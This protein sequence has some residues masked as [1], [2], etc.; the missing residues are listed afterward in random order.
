MNAPLDVPAEGRDT[1]AEP[2]AQ[3][4][5]DA[6]AIRRGHLRVRT[7][8]SLRWVTL[9][10]E[11]ALLAAMAFGLGYPAPYFTAAVVV[12]AGAFVCVLPYELTPEQT[13]AKIVAAMQ[14]GASA[15]SC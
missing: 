4:V 9:A 8:V 11:L 14:Q 13:A 2:A 15:D 10:G 7:L 12:A 5:W 1:V 6:A 3:D